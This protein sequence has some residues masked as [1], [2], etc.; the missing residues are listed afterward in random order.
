MV[1]ESEAALKR[2]EN[3]HG[4]CAIGLSLIKNIG[5]ASPEF[6]EHLQTCHLCLDALILEQRA[7]NRD[8]SAA[9]KKGVI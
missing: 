4:Y 3:S 7:I 6:A 1:I 5:P 2:D 9:R 8:I